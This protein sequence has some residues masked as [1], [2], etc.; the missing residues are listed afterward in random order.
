VR[1][2]HARAVRLPRRSSG[3]PLAGPDRSGGARIQEERGERNVSGSLGIDAVDADRSVATTRIIVVAL[4]IGPPALLGA[5]LLVPVPAPTSFPALPAALAGLVALAVGYRLYR[6]MMGRIASDSISATRLVAI[7]TATI[8][9]LAVTEAAAILGV[10][11]FCFSRE[12]M[13]LTGVATHLI[14][15]GAVWPTR[16]RLEGTS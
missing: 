15:A 8:A 11:A 1:V 3:K 10:I 14:L 2:W 5:A 16:G 9:S 12:P 6:S 7:R 13:A 4:S